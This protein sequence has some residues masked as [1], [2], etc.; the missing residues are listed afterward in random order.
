MVLVG[1]L[2][3][4]FGAGG[5]VGAD[6]LGLCEG[7]WSARRTPF[8]NACTLGFLHGTVRHGIAGG[9]I[10]DCLAVRVCVCVRMYVQGS[11]GVGFAIDP[12]PGAAEFWERSWGTVGKPS[13]SLKL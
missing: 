3:I 5:L 13:C 11:L 7:A 12:F 6:A 9:G 2:P 8:G 4:T 10:F 1:S